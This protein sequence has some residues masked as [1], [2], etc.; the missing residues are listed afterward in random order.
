MRKLGIV[1]FVTALAG[2]RD[3]P[4]EQPLPAIAS[5][6]Q[7]TAPEPVAVAQLPV[8]H[9]VATV[10]ASSGVF[11]VV[12]VAENDVLNVRQEPDP[13]SKKVFSYAPRQ[14]NIAGT[15]QRVEKAGTPW[16]EVKLATGTGWVNRFF[17]SETKPSGG[18]NDPELTALIRAFM[19]AVVAADGAALKAL[20]SPL[21]G[22]SV[23]PESRVLTFPFG[24]VDTLFSSPVV[25]NLGPGDGG[26]PDMTG[27]FAE[28]LAPSLR[29][30]ISGKGAI[31]AC[32]KLNTGSS[33]SL[34]PTLEQYA[35]V[36][37]VSFF[38]PGQPDGHDWVTWVGS[39][40]YVDGKPFFSALDRF[41]WEI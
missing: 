27:T 15:G 29:Q 2:C 6:A 5:A 41:H 8:S 9:A 30:A 18:C 11:R 31:E 37:P 32:G 23:R 20:V 36:T 14:Q 39:I 3:K 24:S 19:R 38:F 17:L 34:P 28:R 12:G 4:K 10:P 33:T 13:S 25:L 22:L 16:V 7:G 40:E 21:R 1:L 26:G 35:A